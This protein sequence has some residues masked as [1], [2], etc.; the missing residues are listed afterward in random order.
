MKRQIV[1]IVHYGT[2]RVVYDDQKKCNPFRVSLNGKKVE[3]RADLASCLYLLASLV[4]ARE[5]AAGILADNPALAAKF[6]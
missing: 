6:R 4:P 3:D 5:A 2:W 1:K